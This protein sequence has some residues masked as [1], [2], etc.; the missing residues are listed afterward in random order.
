MLENRTA[1]Y[2]VY[3]RHSCRIVVAFGVDCSTSRGAPLCSLG[4][5]SAPLVKVYLMVGNTHTCPHESSLRVENSY[6]AEILKSTVREALMNCAE[7]SRLLA[8]FS[9]VLRLYSRM[10]NDPCPVCVPC[11]VLC[12]I[13]VFMVGG[14]TYEDCLLYTSPSP[15]DLS[16]SRMPSS[17]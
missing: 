5:A 12:Q 4:G 7:T 15:R 13:I 16:T 6:F 2:S 10:V 8:L 9:C 1:S 14:V 11:I 3:G 17:A